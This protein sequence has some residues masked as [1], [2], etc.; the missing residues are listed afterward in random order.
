ML[1]FKP[2]I[3]LELVIKSDVDVLPAGTTET[4]GIIVT[5]V[6][7]ILGC[8]G[9][10]F[11]TETETSKKSVTLMFRQL[12]EYLKNYESDKN[13]CSIQYLGTQHAVL[14]FSHWILQPGTL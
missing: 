3:L 2:P 1:N 7:T 4:F 10:M 6:K 5:G 14:Q 13:I 11:E 9:I 8:E 12:Y